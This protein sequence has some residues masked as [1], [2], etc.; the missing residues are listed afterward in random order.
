MKSNKQFMIL[1]A[2]GIVMVV[3]CHAGSSLGLG[4]LFFPYNSFFMPMFMFISGYFVSHKRCV[5]EPLKYIYRKVTT[6]LLPYLGWMLYYTAFLLLLRLFT[7][8]NLVPNLSIV[9][10]IKGVFWSGEMMG[11]NSPGYFAL[12][13]FYVSV[14]MILL[15]RLFGKFWND[16]LMMI[17]FVIIGSLV[18]RYSLLNEHNF[19]NST[20]F[21]MMLKVAISLQFFQLGVLYKEKLEKWLSKINIVITVLGLYSIIRIIQHLFGETRW[22]LNR[23]NFNES[24]LGVKYHL[25]Y[26][27]P[28]VISTM[29]ILLWVKI[30]MFLVPVLENSKLCNFIS[31]HTFGIMMHHIS[32]MTFLNFVLAAINRVKCI[33]GFDSSAALSSAWYRYSWDGGYAFGVYYFIIGIVVACLI[34]YL[35]DRIKNTLKRARKNIQQKQPE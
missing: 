31:N 13:L 10:Y 32:G 35:V 18:A 12:I 2:I 16:Y 24:W 20:A 34:C 28:F 3:D 8:A 19:A 22:S 29:G 4:T 9:E 25:G 17:V 21:N 6:I 33:S 14:I 15:R 5:E 11:I 30:A 23:L 27:M 26:F 7:P 1:S